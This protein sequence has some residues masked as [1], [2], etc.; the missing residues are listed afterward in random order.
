MK[1]LLESSVVPCYE[2][3]YDPEVLSSEFL[4][5]TT[6]AWNKSIVLLEATVEIELK[7]YNNNANI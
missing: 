4:L 6:R 3:V 7:Q 1:V 5:E 2:V